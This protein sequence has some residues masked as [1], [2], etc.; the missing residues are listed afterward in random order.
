MPLFWCIQ[1]YTGFEDQIKYYIGTELTRGGNGKCSSTECTTTATTTTTTTALDRAPTSMLP[2]LA[3]LSVNLASVGAWSVGVCDPCCGSGTLL[4]ASASV[5]ASAVFGA[6]TDAVRLHTGNIGNRERVVADACSVKLRAECLDAIICDPPYDI[7]AAATTTPHEFDHHH[8]HGDKE[9]LAA[10]QVIVK[11]LL[12]GLVTPSLR[13]FGRFVCWMPHCVGNEAWLKTLSSEI[14][15]N[16]K[17]SGGDHEVVLVYYLRETRATGVQRAVAVWEKRPLD[18]SIQRRIITRRK[19]APPVNTTTT[20]TTTTTTATATTATATTHSTTVTLTEQSRLQPYRE[21]RKERKGAC[22][23][24]WRASWLGDIA[25]LQEFISAGGDPNSRD[26]KAHQ[27]PLQFAAG[28]NRLSAV[29]ALLAAGADPR[30]AD[31]KEGTTALHRAA[32]RGHTSV[33]DA[34]LMSGRADAHQFSRRA[35]Q[36]PLMMAAQFGHEDATLC[37]L[38]YFSC[39]GEEE[40]EKAVTAVDGG[41]LSA[42]HVA[43]QWGKA[44]IIQLFVNFIVRN[45]DTDGTGIDLNVMSQGLCAGVSPA[46]LAARWGHVD[47]L[48]VLHAAGADLKVKSGGGEGKMPLDEAIE[49]QRPACVDY[50]TTLNE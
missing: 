39:G 30:S 47:V 35:Q 32:A 38:R 8:H 16:A 19:V 11:S 25:A 36:T 33:V 7:R 21:T 4:Q 27:T 22:L 28:Y 5:G 9:V 10:W 46:H 14:N 2:A 3:A 26:P 15:N 49:W 29:Q 20:T 24:I 12:A 31:D 23:D 43:A 18:S 44:S 42:V 40:V 37:L 34:L 48:R 6:D 1:V 13:V 41:G 45:G 50:L 17:Q